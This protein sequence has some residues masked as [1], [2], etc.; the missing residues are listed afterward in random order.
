LLSAVELV[1]NPER[2]GTVNLVSLQERL[3]VSILHLVC[4][5]GDTKSCR[6]AFKHLHCL[7][8]FLSGERPL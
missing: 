2:D 7:I 1:V 8:D 6:V 4:L 3:T 5:Q